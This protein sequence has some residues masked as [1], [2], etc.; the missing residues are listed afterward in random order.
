M[1]FTFPSRYL[2]AIGLQGVF[3]L[4]GWSRLIH[5]EFLVFPAL[6]G[7]Q[8]RCPLAHWLSR[9]M[10]GLSRPSASS[11]TI[12]AVPYRGPEP[13]GL[14]LPVRSPLLGYHFVFSSCRYWMF[15]FPGSP[16]QLVAGIIADGLP[17]SDTR[18][19]TA[20]CASRGVSPL[21]VLPRLLEPRY[22]PSAL[23]FFSFLRQAFA[24][25]RRSHLF[26]YS[27][28]CQW[29]LSPPLREDSP[30]DSS[31]ADRRFPLPFR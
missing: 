23:A 4:T 5:T 8:P 28:E 13:G 20:A 18:G 3:S 17:H 14:A 1:L 26:L 27:S 11:V 6:R 30:P 25:W 29:S 2:F 19:S 10:A 31:A 7:I 21:A 22:P 24:D 9:F 12:T 16:C 15:Q